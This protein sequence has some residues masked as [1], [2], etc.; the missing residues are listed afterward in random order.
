MTLTHLIPSL[1]TTL[2]DP[3]SRDRWPEFT[4]ATTTDVTIAGVSLCRLVDWCDTP[5]VHTAAAVRPGTGGRPSQNELASVVVMRVESIGRSSS[6]QTEVW[7]DARLDGC[8]SVLAETRLIGR[9]S[10][11]F[12]RDF[13]LRPSSADAATV[14]IVQLPA[15]LREGDLLVVPCIG[16]TALQSVRGWTGHPER[17]SEDRVDHER[18]LFPA[19]HCSR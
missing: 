15:D 16:V 18:E 12:V 2:P 14:R 11:A 17:L 3:I 5:C 8:Q 4:T 19:T 10:T 6:G 13:V 1:R 7:V 9:A